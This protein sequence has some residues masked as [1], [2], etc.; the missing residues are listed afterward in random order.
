MTSLVVALLVIVAVG[1]GVTVADN[2]GRRFRPG[3]DPGLGAGDPLIGLCERYARGEI[4][5]AEFDRH[6]DRLLPAA[7]PLF[8][9]RASGW[10][11]LG[12]KGGGHSGV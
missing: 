11:W 3:T 4:G 6:L 8:P 10:G 1:V 2:R 5:D 12:G 7:P 9:P